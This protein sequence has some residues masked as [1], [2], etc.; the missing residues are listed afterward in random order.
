MI[1][2]LGEKYGFTVDTPVKDIPEDVLNKIFFGSDEVLKLSN[3]PLGVTSNYFMTFEGVVNYVGQPGGC[4]RTQ[5]K[6]QRQGAVCPVPASAPN[7]AA[8]G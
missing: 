2:A 4:Q 1:E 7:A 8:P 3:T 5:G 6:R